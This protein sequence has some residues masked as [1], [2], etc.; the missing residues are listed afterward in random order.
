MITNANK[1]KFRASQIGKIMTNP[2]TN[3]KKEAGEISEGAKTYCT[4][5]FINMKYGRYKDVESKYITKGLEVE[6]DSINLYARHSN[7]F[8]VK[9]EEWF[10]NDYFT[11]TPDIILPDMIIDVKSVWD[12]FTFFSNHPDKIKK[13]YQYQLLTY[14]NLTGRR[15]SALEYCLIST[16]EMLIMDELRRLQW[17]MGILDDSNPL[18]IEASEKLER[19]LRFADIP[20]SERILEVPVKYSEVTVNAMITRVEQCRWWMNKELFKVVTV[21]T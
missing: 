7:T 12:L 17:K 20:E 13:L 16:P 8:A 10:E 14:M 1:I 18:F 9:N 19:N 3:E 2:K 6:R 15:K 5:L 11:G 21:T 4:E